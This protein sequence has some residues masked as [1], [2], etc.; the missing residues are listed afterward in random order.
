MKKSFSILLLSFRLV[1]FAQSDV[2]LWPIKG[3]KTGE[4]ILY[5]PQSYIEKELNTDLIISACKGTQVQ[6]P[7]DA[8]VF[9][10]NYVYH[11]SLLASTMYRVPPSNFEKDSTTF[12]QQGWDSSEDINYLSVVLGLKLEDGKKM[13]ISGLRP[14]K[15]FKTG[16]KVKRGDIIGIVGYYYKAIKQPAIAI[17]IST[18]TGKASDPMSPFGLKTTFRKFKPKDKTILSV[19][20][21]TFDIEVLRNALEEGLPGLYDYV[22]KEELNTAISQASTSIQKP[23]KTDDFYYVI[24]NLICKIRDNHTSILSQ[25]PSYSRKETYLPT[26]AI[27]WINDSLIVTRTQTHQSNYY[28][29][30][31]KAVDGIPADLFKEKIIPYIE[32]IDG[33]VESYQNYMLATMAFLRYFNFCNGASSKHDIS[34]TFDNNETIFFP[35]YK[36][37]P[38]TCRDLQPMFKYFYLI[39]SEKISFE[40]ISNNTA[41]LG[42]SSFFINEMN[43]EK[44]AA[45]IVNITDSNYQ[46]LIIDIR[47][48]PGGA[49]N[50]CAK[51]FSYIA[52]EPFYISAYSQVN[53]KGDFDFFKY[54]ANYA[55][56]QEIF[57][58]YYSLTGNDGYYLY[59]DEV[60]LPDKNVSFKGNVYVLINE[61]SCSASAIFAGLLHKYKRGVLVGRETASVYHQMKAEKFANLRL[62]NSNLDINIPLVRVVFDSCQNSDIPYGRGVLPD[63]PVNLTLEELSFN[64]GDSILNYVQQLIAN[65]EYIKDSDKNNQTLSNNSNKYIYFFCIILLCLSI[66]WLVIIMK[67]TSPK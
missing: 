51:I 66:V 11:S 39:N 40:Q 19:E 16:E 61:R 48:N 55:E 4:N 35:G 65:N 62:P 5:K 34:L 23:I 21:A 52:L 10:Y 47:N 26:I 13:Y 57:P 60:I 45:F 24:Q 54:T 17:G 56:K 43:I 15:K 59:N 14:I 33:R 27:G 36:W 29:Q 63:Y 53:K 7:A 58:E 31:V 37:N 18:E 67:K 49:E 42:L 46:N 32:N 28:K 38:K 2:F 50:V 25:D 30:Q 9:L 12:I 3:A 8:E 22:S 41:Y 44:I 6:A 64:N 1:C 20:E